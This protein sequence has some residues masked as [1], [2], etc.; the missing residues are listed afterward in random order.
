MAYTST[1]KTPQE[2]LLATSMTLTRE[3]RPW[4]TGTK[5]PAQAGVSVKASNSLE[6]GVA[7]Q[8]VLF[9]NLAQTLKRFNLD[10]PHPFAG[11]ADFLTNFFQGAAFMAAQA[12][13]ADH[14]LTLLVGQFG[15]PLIDAL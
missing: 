12:E 4:N 2:Y 14:H 13:A 7:R 15:Q 1:H 3:W 11:Q 10:L 9:Q 6:K 5:N 8:A